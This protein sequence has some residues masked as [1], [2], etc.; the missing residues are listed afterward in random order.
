MSSSY[1][2]LNGRRTARVSCWWAGWD[3]EGGR[4]KPE[5]RKMPENG[6]E[7][8]QSAA[9]CV[10]RQSYFDNQLLNYVPSLLP[11]RSQVWILG[12][13]GFQSVRLLRWLAR[14]HW[15]F[16]I[17]QPGNNQVC[18]AGQ[19]WIKLNA[20]PL[21]EG[22]TRF[23]GWVRLAEKHNAGWFW[24]ILHWESGEDEP[25]LLVADQAGGN[26]LIRLYR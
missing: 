8:H 3:S 10:R 24:L 17:R 23:I 7:S 12:D 2:N 19:P 5:A 9:R 16:V 20:I 25:W 18:W 4:K 15:H 14:Q 13:A 22:K 11:A 21:A 1:K 26:R 6:D